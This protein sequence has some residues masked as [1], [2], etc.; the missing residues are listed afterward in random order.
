MALMRSGLAV[1]A[2]RAHRGRGDV[3]GGDV[4]VH[5]LGQV[6]T[7][8][9]NPVSATSMPYLTRRFA[10]ASGAAFVITPR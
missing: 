4:G 7:V 6:A 9:T 5:R 3:M 2:P 8:S 1:R 10:K